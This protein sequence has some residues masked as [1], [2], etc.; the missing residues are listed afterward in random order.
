M[1]VYAYITIADTVAKLMLLGILLF[2]PFDKLISYAVGIMVIAIVTNAIYVVYNQQKIRGT[3]IY[4]Y[5][6]GKVFRILTGYTGWS[7]FG[8]VSAVMCNQGMTILMNIFFGVAVN[9]AKAISDRIM[10]I[11]QSFVMNFYMAVSPQIV[12]TY[13]AGDLAYTV[14]LA[15]SSTR[16]AFYLM[17]VLSVPTI[18][19]LDDIMQLWLGDTCTP[20]MILFTRLSLIFAIVNV[21]ET[22]ITFM[23][24]ATGRLKAYQLYVGMLTLAIIPVSYVLYKMGLPAYTA[25]VCQTVIYAV[26]QFVRVWVARRHYPITMSGYIREVLLRPVLVSVAVTLA[27]TM[28]YAA[29][30]SAWGNA[31][32]T[33]FLLLALIWLYGLSANEKTMV[34]TKLKSKLQK[35]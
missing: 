28:L 23:M 29:G 7:F 27:A 3:R 33:T 11:V 4:Y 14:H 10:T 26:V 16:L 22:P 8:S 19:L 17:M 13:A 34:K 6:D 18:I 12:K 20:D 31:V 9:A 25:F 32:I 2:S 30:L 15:Y 5:W 1:G 35:R 21:F 24:R